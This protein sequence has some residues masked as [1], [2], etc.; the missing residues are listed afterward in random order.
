MFNTSSYGKIKC[1]LFN[2]IKLDYVNAFN[3]G[4]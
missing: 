3:S 4:L 1:K 2:I